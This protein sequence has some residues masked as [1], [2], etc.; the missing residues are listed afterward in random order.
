[1]TSIH[2]SFLVSLAA[3][4]GISAVFQIIYLALT[5]SFS[6][7]TDDPL[8]VVVIL[9]QGITKSVFLGIGGLFQSGLSI[10]NTLETGGDL[11]AALGGLVLNIGFVL[12]PVIAAI[13]AGLLAESKVDA[14]FGWLLTIIICWTV[15]TIFYAINL[16]AAASNYQSIA[17]TIVIY[18][19]LGFV[20]LDLLWA[21]L[22]M[23]SASLITV[24]S[25][26]VLALTAQRETFY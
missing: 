10:L 11:V 19:I 5:D 20:T 14:F 26:G 12:A 16:G 24:F 15:W 13:V 22:I 3:F 1:M 23:L 18:L 4:V 25:Y 2:K 6:L 9:F 7:I 17:E 8:Y 21:I